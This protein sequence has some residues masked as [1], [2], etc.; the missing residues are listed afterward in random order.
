[1]LAEGDLRLPQFL[2]DVK[3]VTFNNVKARP[4]RLPSLPSFVPVVRKGSRSLLAKMDFPFVA[5]SLGDVI[6]EKKLSIASDIRKK[7]GVGK[8]TKIILLSYGSDP[9]LE[10]IWT[11][12][13]EVLSKIALLDFDLIT[14][15]NF[16]IWLPQPHAERLINL[17]RSLIVFEEMQNLGLPAIP[18]LYWS[19]K[20]D[21][22]RWAEWINQNKEVKTIA[23][24]LQTLR[25]NKDWGRSIDELQILS[26]ALNRPLHFLIT[27]PST[28]K[29]VN[30]IANLFPCLTISNGRCSRS[31]ACGFL[32]EKKE[33]TLVKTYRPDLNKKVILS[34][35]TVI[36]NQIIAKQ[37][38]T[39]QP[40]SFAPPKGLVLQRED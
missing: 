17:K 36:Y 5:V 8:N 9:L 40:Y 25:S 15:I 39:N 35:N 19:G 31:A 18:H 29:R 14:S 4:A 37:Q 33:D 11:N 21:L 2:A 38:A 34:Q 13:R 20:K 7:F 12:R 1:M 30:Q 22:L 24:N 3:G 32:L 10:N 26:P 16:S 23:I 27:G 6:S 28:T